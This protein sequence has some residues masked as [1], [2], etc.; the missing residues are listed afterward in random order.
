MITNTELAKLKPKQIKHNNIYYYIKFNYNENNFFE[1]MELY[2]QN[3]NLSVFSD[4]YITPKGTIEDISQFYELVFTEELDIV[5]DAVERNN[6]AAMYSPTYIQD[7]MEKFFEMYLITEERKIQA[8]Q[9][10]KL[11]LE[12]YENWDGVIE[13]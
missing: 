7:I 4:S 12:N 2:K 6:L 13:L 10:R 11:Q 3:K 1:I 9:K 8:E 5:I